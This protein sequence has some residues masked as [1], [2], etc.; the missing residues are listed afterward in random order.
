MQVI[1]ITG[2]AGSGKDTVGDILR[3]K[4]DFATTKLAFP[5]QKIVCG[6]FGFDV[7]KWQDREWRE[8]VQPIYDCSPRRLAQT[9]GTEWGRN[10]VKHSLWLDLTFDLIKKEVLDPVAITDVRF[11]NEAEF[12]RGNGGFMIHVHRSNLEGIEH[13]GHQSERGITVDP[14]DFHIN[15]YSTLDVLE[16]QVDHVMDHIQSILA[17]RPDKAEEEAA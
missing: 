9:L 6:L 12:I 5:I 15:N 10:S 16:E 1:G 14:R 3:D 8:A 11:N 17:S 4:Y 13:R 2:K 7:D